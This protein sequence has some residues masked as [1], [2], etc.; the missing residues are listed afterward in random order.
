MAAGWV[1]TVLTL[2]LAG[3][4]PGGQ[5]AP[6][7]AG[8]IQ[9]LGASDCL[10]SS[11]Q[12]VAEVHYLRPADDDVRLPHWTPLACVSS[13]KPTL[14]VPCLIAT[15]K[16]TAGRLG[17]AHAR[18]SAGTGRSLEFTPTEGAKGRARNGYVAHGGRSFTRPA[19]PRGR[20]R[21][22]CQRTARGA[23]GRST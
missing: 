11:A 16:G 3:F 5:D 15:D 12:V 18:R 6:R 14:T 19:Q 17:G 9:A 21:R 4:H 1:K 22:S 20:A 10:E 23:A 8:H 7:G 2:A 13:M